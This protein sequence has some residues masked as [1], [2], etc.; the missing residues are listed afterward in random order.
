MNVNINDF[1]NLS[2]LANFAL[3]F[4]G[5]LVFLLV[6][7]YVNLWVTPY[8]E[9]KLIKEA[10]NSAAA[11]T[12]GGS[13]VGYSIAISGVAASSVNFLDF[14]VWGVVGAITQ[15]VAMLIVRKL[16][17]PAFV[18]R[19]EKN[20]IPAAIVAAAFYIAI[21]VLNSACMSY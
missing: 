19:I 5:A 4:V 12:L 3:Y 20:E 18:E 13:L 1:I 8:D 14:C 6:F 10:K 21:G 9:W 2:G 11:I 16:F 15:F 7:K 17:M